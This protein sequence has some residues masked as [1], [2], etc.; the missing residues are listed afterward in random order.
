METRNA[1]KASLFKTLKL[2]VRHCWAPQDMCNKNA[3]R[4]HS[5]QKANILEQL[6]IN[7]HVIMAEDRII[8]KGEAFSVKFNEVGQNEASTFTGLCKDHDREIFSPIETAEINLQSGQHLFL[9]A[10]RSVLKKLHAISLEAVKL[11]NI[12]E[13]QVKFG[14][15]THKPNDPI[16]DLVM[17]R[18]MRSYSTSLYKRIFDIAYL[19]QRYNVLKHELFSFEQE[20]ATI[21]VSGLYWLEIEKTSGTDGTGVP[22]LILNVFPDKHMTHIIFSYLDEDAQYVRLHLDELLNASLRRRLWSISKTIIEFCDNFVISPIYWNNL[23]RIRRDKIVRYYGETCI[24]KK[25]YDGNIQDLCLFAPRFSQR[26]NMQY[27]DN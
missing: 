6:V 1:L 16:L 25:E 13:E 2:Q 17:M 26:R 19:S 24:N 8:E 23:S 27:E 21:A 5:L 11:E 7:G 15:A 9:L 12:Y 4:A 22:R 18:L 3:I 20:R 14:T 10:Y